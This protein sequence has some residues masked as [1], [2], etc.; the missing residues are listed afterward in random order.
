MKEEL[1][2]K[3]VTPSFSVHLMNNW[4]QYTQGNKSSKEYIK[5]FDEFLIR[6]NTLH[7]E[8]EAQI[9]SRFRAGLRDDLWTKLLAREV[10][11]LEAMYTLVQ[12]LDST[13]INHTFKSHDYRALVSKPSPSSQPNRF[14]IQIPSHRDDIKGKSHERDNINKS[15]GPPK[16]VSQ[17]SAT[18]VKVTDT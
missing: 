13:R 4:H 16:L 2:I 11:E 18:Y 9:L 1:E 8:E 12:N 14:N 3:Y 6:C 17:P 15:L 5:K 10:N 7:K